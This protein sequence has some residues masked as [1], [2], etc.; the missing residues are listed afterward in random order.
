MCTPWV[1]NECAKHINIC[2]A[3]LKRCNMIVSKPSTGT[4]KHRV[5]FVNSFMSQPLA[6]FPRPKS[7]SAYERTTLLGGCVSTKVKNSNTN[8]LTFL[9]ESTK[10]NGVVYIRI[11]FY[12]KPL[13]SDKEITAMEPHHIQRVNRS[14]KIGMHDALYLLRSN[15]NNI[16]YFGR[17]E[18]IT[19]L[20]PCVCELVYIVHI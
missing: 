4:Y 9:A 17:Q 1:V 5:D 20:L 6:S 11:W 15:N 8:T 12:G 10:I 19:C 16:S 2:S 7:I 18:N 14:V 3:T 13:R